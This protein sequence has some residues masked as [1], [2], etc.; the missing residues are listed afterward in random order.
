MRGT[1]EYEVP[2]IVP[3]ETRLTDRDSSGGVQEYIEAVSFM[4][5]LQHESLINLE[6]V[7]QALQ[8]EDGTEASPARAHPHLVSPFIA[9][10]SPAR[11]LDS[12]SRSLKKIML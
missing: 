10:I 3:W 12:L 4:H 9:D 6:Q 11:P 8:E 5:Y 7:R 2:P 1:C